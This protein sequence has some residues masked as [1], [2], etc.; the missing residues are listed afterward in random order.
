MSEWTS[1]MSE[2]TAR[3][4]R[5]QAQTY[6]LRVSIYKIIFFAFVMTI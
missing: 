2:T 4:T 5:A 6:R 3:A 1:I